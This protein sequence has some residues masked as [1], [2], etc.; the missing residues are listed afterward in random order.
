M[1]EHVIDVTM[2]YS[3]VLRW[4]FQVEFNFEKMVGACA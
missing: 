4:C 1:S 2:L 3:N